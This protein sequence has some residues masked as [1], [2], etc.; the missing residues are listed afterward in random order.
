MNLET[1]RK[2]LSTKER[3]IADLSRFIGGIQEKNPNYSLL[4][5]SGCSV[6]SGIKSGSMLCDLWRED[7]FKNIFVGSEYTV[8]NAKQKLAATY[9]SWYD[10]RN[11]YSS[12]FEKKYDLPRQRRRFVE[13]EVS[14][15]EPSIGYA[16][17]IQLIENSYFNTIFTTNFDDLINEAFYQFSKNR[18]IVCAHDSSISSITVTSKR[19]KIIKLH[20]D[21]LFDDIKSTLKETESLENN[22]RNKF[23]EFAKDYGL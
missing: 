4:L 8:D 13:S 22:I 21:Y 10:P 3:S 20:G 16:Y 12:L 17:L 9:S 5:G 1:L 15:N 2:E 6:S 23:I 7:I 19:P 14:D 18:P 11:E